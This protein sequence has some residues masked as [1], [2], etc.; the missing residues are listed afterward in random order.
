L[1]AALRSY[2]LVELR[3]YARAH[4]PFVWFFLL[5]AVASAILGP[6]L[7]GLDAVGATGRVTIGFA[8]M[9]SYMSV[10]YTG[11]ALYR[12][13]ASAT[14]R[15]TAI[16]SPARSAYLVGK[17]LPVLA[18]TAAQLAVFAAC[19]VALLDLPLR[20]GALAGTAQV[21]V[22]LLPLAGT[23]VAIGAGLFTL[24]RRAEIFFSAT[25]LVLFALAAVGGAIVPSSR[26][27]EWSRIA[28]YA[29]PHYWAMRALDESTLGAGSWIVVLESA[30]I[31][32]LFTL[33]VIGAAAWRLDLRKER[34]AA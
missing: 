1:S 16:A 6:E 34:Y 8:V 21:A 33:A 9:F 7:A 18:I 13:Y 11:R 5:P 3:A 24:L 29:T 26:L 14:W 30:A 25:Y 2:A 15:R 28:G 27:P 4:Y 31:L 19:A 22:V 23:G 12:E 17:C 10:N 20:A 32:M